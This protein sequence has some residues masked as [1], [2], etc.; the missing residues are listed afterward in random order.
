MAT[1][2]KVDEKEMLTLCRADKILDDRIDYYL[3]NGEYVGI[4]EELPLSKRDDYVEFQMYMTKEHK[5]IT[6]RWTT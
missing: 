1:Y 5:T 3:V 2:F 4:L 6:S